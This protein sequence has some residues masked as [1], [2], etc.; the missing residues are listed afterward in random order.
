MNRRLLRYIPLIIWVIVMLSLSSRPAVISAE[1]SK[2]FEQSLSVVQEK[3]KSSETL[4]VNFKVILQSPKYL[5]RKTAHVILYCGLYMWTAFAFIFETKRYRKY[6]KIL[7][8]CI[9]YACFDEVYQP[10]Y[11]AVQD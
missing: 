6:F 10:L 3:I 7:L 5:V 4:N 9:L 8:F 1:D 11:L 2:P